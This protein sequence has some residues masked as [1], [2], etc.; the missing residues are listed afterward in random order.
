MLQ[1]VLLLQKAPPAPARRNLPRSAVLIVVVAMAVMLVQHREILV[2][3]IVAKGV[4]IG[5]LGHAAA[6][7]ADRQ[8]LT[9]TE[10]A[11][12][13]RVGA[14]RADG[15][16]F[17]ADPHETVSGEGQSMPSTAS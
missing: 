1:Q 7:I 10:P 8:H 5:R 2:V 17:A 6:P 13:A 12:F 11:L 9:R 14:E 3:S 16:G 4:R 15:R